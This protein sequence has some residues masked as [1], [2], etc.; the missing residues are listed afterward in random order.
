MRYSCI[1]V[2]TIHLNTPGEEEVNITHL[3]QS[4]L[5]LNIVIQI[6]EARA[7]S[8]FQITQ[9]AL[10]QRLIK[11]LS[12]ADTPPGSLITVTRTNT[13]TSGTDLAATKTGLLQTIHNRVQVQ[14]DMRAVGDEAALAGALKTLLLVGG[15]F[16]EETG[17]VDDRAS[18]DQVDTGGRDQ[19]RGQNVEVIS[20]RAMDDRMAGI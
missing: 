3:E 15:Q 6:T 9:L 13:L 2:R 18:T 4:K 1:I 8:A 5:I 20:I 17:D 16:L 19:A 11:D 10:K 14:T 7:V 12:N